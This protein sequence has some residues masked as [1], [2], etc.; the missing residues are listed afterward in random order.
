MDKF[1]Y[2]SNMD[3][4]AV[5]HLYQNFRS[6]PTS[7]TEDWQ[8]FFAGFDFAQELYDQDDAEFGIPANVKKEFDV[9]NLINGYRKNGHLF[10]DTNPVRARRKYSPTLE[11]KN[12]GLTDADLDIVFRAG[13]LIGIGPAPLRQIVEHLEHTYCQSIGVEYMY[14]RNPEMVQWLQK[15]IE[16]NRNQPD[17]DLEGKI[18]IHKKLSEAV[19]FEEFL[20][21]KFPGQKRFS[22]EGA[23]SLIPALD[24]VI[25]EGSN[26]GVD[27]FVIGMAHRGRLN[28]LSNILHKSYTDI[29]SEFEG[30]D[31]EDRDV[32]GDVKYHMGFTSNQIS[33]K[34]K[35][36]KLNLCPNPSH[37]EAVDPV[38]EGISRAKIDRKFKGDNSKLC[39]ILIHGD[40]AI[41]G[42]GVVYEVVQMA[43]LDGYKT[44]G[45]IHIVVNNQVGFTTNYL[46]G[47]TSVY[48]TDV[49]KVTLSPVFHVNGDDV[50]AV[51]RTTQIAMQFR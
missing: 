4:S 7:V 39:P 19:L 26:L 20:G 27:E 30:K 10:T 9:I 5:E 25:Q 16:T 44:G 49:A 45:T 38:V 14:I 8:Q 32:E 24:A 33:D 50:E 2:L 13:T 42:Q 48:C 12:F 1:S 29:F 15:V 23:E 21:K 11:I 34:G 17:F 43:K 40:A 51:A 6:D 36:I 37:L 47:R 41:A 28:I 22:L 46:D 31:Y 3:V 35:D 18:Q